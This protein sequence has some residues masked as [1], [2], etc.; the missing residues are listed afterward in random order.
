MKKA[1]EKQDGKETLRKT[2]KG[3]KIVFDIALFLFGL[4]F[5]AVIGFIGVRLWQWLAPLFS[6]V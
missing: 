5:V 4:V 6:N 1:T 3:V 2:A